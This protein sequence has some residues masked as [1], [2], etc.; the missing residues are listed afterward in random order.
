MK[1]QDQKNKLRQQLLAQR[2]NI[3][4][5]DF[6]RWSEQITSKLKSQAAFNQ[7]ETVHC[8]VSMN[9]RREVNTHPLIK[10]ML[11]GSKKVV[12][13]IT[14]ID[15]GTL[16]HTPLHA[17]DNLKANDWGV[18][19]PPYQHDISVDFLDLVIVPMVGGDREGNRIGYGEGFYDRFL[20]EVECPKMGLLFECCLVDHIPTE[21]FDVPLDSII[22]ENGVY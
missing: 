22:T 13:P 1:N 16:R 5:G 7:A 2:S 17:F 15:S 11:A 10:Q 18:L 14:Q 6:A 20:S 8:Y 3:S 19:E 9:E 12:V 4:E 21:S